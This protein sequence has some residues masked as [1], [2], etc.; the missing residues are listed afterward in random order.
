MLKKIIALIFILGAENA[1][2]TQ[3]IVWGTT[4]HVYAQTETSTGNA[5]MIH[6]ANGIYNNGQHPWCGNRVF[7][8]FGDKVLMSA[9]I[10]ASVSKQTVNFIYEDAAP[11]KTVQSHTTSH[12]KLISIFTA[13]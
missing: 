3:Y 12:C 7:V 4:I 1:F 2:C 11:G 5:H 10:A 8:D 9:A 6:S 13:P